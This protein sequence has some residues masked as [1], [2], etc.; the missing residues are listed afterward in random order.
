MTR[1]HH[2]DGLSVR[3]REFEAR[4]ARN[5]KRRHLVVVGAP[6]PDSRAIPRVEPSLGRPKRCGSWRHEGNRWLTVADFA[7]DSRRADH[8][9]S[10]C[11][12]CVRKRQSGYKRPTR[13]RIGEV[14]E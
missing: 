12:V 11:K 5:A 10:E 7:R 4:A 3:D 2:T 6:E 9:V 13:I 1:A 8:H 14:T